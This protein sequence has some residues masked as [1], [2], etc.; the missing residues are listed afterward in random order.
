MINEKKLIED[1]NKYAR[2]NFHLTDEFEWVLEGMLK[3][4]DIV[5]AQPKVG[6]WIPVE[7]RLPS[8]FEHVLTCDKIGNIHVLWHHTSFDCPFNISWKH[9]DFYPVIAWMPLPESYNA[10]RGGKND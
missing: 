8:N 1:L 9:P 3:A 6:E 4:L 2:E 10:E 5:E 7:E